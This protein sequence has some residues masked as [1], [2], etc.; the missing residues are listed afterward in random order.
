M[1]ILVL[2]D[3]H[4]RIE[5]LDIVERENADKVV[6]LG[7][8]VSTHD[9]VSAGQQLSIMEDFFNMKEQDPDKFILLR[10]N[11]DTQHA[12]YAWAE[13]S[14]YDRHVASQ[15]PKE[16]WLEL[17][18]WLYTIDTKDTTLVFS[19][20]GI[21]GT[22]FTNAVNYVQRNSAD[23]DLSQ[24]TIDDINNVEPCELFGFTPS[25]IGDYSGE[26]CTQPPT[27]IRPT[28]LGNDPLRS[29]TTQIVQVVGHTPVKKITNLADIHN[30][31]PQ[32]WLCDCLPRQYL[33]IDIENDNISFTVKNYS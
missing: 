4:G 7:D 30:E 29:N 17:T 8:F 21:S 32:V 18:Q 10:G 28:A 13:C 25:N 15:F 23:K 27:W 20:A 16:R 5:A 1:K 31:L 22:W 33:V 6:V 9:N 12:G 19:H 24:L 3:I 2:G 26:S 14:G 11:H